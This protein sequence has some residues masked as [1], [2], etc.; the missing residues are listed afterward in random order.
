MTGFGTARAVWAIPYELHP[1]HVSK[2][3]F[4]VVMGNNGLSR[5]A[6]ARSDES[7]RKGAGL[8]PQTSSGPHSKDAIPLL[9]L[10][11]GEL[12]AIDPNRLDAGLEKKLERLWQDINSRLGDIFGHDGLRFHMFR[13]PSFAS[14]LSHIVGEKRTPD[15]LL[16]AYRHLIGQ[17]IGDV[18]S[19]IIV[20]E[21]GEAPRKV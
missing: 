21:K 8:S 16:V 2:G 11:L 4:G 20:L 14:A 9:R 17:L 15:A 3:S 6:G 7:S 18:E 13:Q 5:L 19:A 10:L 12:R 1:Q